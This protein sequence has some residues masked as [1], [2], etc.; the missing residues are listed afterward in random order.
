MRTRTKPYLHGSRKQPGKTGGKKENAGETKKTTLELSPGEQGSCKLGPGRKKKTEEQKQGTCQLQVTLCSKRAGTQTGSRQALGVQF[1]TPSQRSPGPPTAHKHR[2]LLQERA[3]ITASCTA[4]GFQGLGCFRRPSA[5]SLDNHG[6]KEHLLGGASLSSIQMPSL[7]LS[8]RRRSRS[9]PR[10][11][12]DLTASLK[13]SNSPF[14]GQLFNI[15]VQLCWRPSTS[16]HSFAVFTFIR[17]LQ[18]FFLHACG[19]Q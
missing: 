4:D 3:A 16:C 19:C 9:D 7:V 18:F 2:S 5:S 6:Q 15:A 13:S 1:G 10:C 17:W 14:R 11:S 12:N 8:V